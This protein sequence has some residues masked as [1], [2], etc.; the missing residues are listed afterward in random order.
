MNK[1]SAPTKLPSTPPEPA[2]GRALVP[3]TARQRGH[4]EAGPLARHLAEQ[5]SVDLETLHGSGPGGRVTRT[6]VE[7]AAAAGATTRQPR[8]RATPLARRL[9]AEVGVDLATVQGT[10][11]DSAVRAADVRQAA[12]GPS[13]PLPLA[14]A[15]AVAVRP[16]AERP[17]VVHVPDDRGAGVRR[18]ISGL[19]SRPNRDIPHYYL[20]TTVDLAAAMDWLHEH[21]RRSPI[22]ERL[23]PAALLLKA[24]ALAA[25]DVPELN[26]SWT[27][28]TSRPARA[29]IW[30]WPCRCAVEGSSP[31]HSTTPTPWHSRS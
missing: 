12:P 9:A 5:S 3:S 29:Y 8:V 2:R 30:A 28:D 6:D 17:S 13:T 26:G 7:E 14:S 25:R 20:S 19:M 31:P 21:N 16:S 1:A 4:T 27:E 11:R 24:A 22:G 15:D 10:G 18:A 23:L